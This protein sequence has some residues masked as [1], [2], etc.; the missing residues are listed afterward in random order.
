MILGVLVLDEELTWS[1]FAGFALI[2]LGV[3]IVNGV[4]GGRLLTTGQSAAPGD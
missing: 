1:A 2:L 3:M 4:L